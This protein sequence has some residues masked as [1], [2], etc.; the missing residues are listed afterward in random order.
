[1]RQRQPPWN[2]PNPKTQSGHRSHPLSP[3]QKACRQG[4][5]QARAP[6]LPILVDNMH[7]H[8]TGPAGISGGG[9]DL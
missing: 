9:D 3:R 7:A 2:K 6:S 4:S 1:M 5:S 8:R